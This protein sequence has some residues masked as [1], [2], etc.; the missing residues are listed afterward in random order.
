MPLKACSR[1]QVGRRIGRGRRSLRREAT[2]GMIAILAVLLAC[3]IV[4]H[5]DAQTAPAQKSV[6][7][8]DG[9]EHFIPAQMQTWKVPGLAIAVVQD[10]QV[11][12]SRGFGLR[13]VKS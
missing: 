12:Y 5:A 6:H 8:I 9:L 13:D 1:E 7:S 4:L 11:I 3:A 2:Q 10:G